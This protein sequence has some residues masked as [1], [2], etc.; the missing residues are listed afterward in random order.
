MRGATECAKRLKL[1]FSS[2]RSKLGKVGHPPLSDP[3]TQMALGILSRDTPE[4]KACEGLDRLRG[5]VVDYNELRV[6]P[7]IELAEILADF[8]DARLKCEDISR[9]L[10]AVFALEHTVSLERLAE[11]PKKETLAYL[12]ELDGLEAYTVA[13]LRLLGLRQ[14]AIPLD[15]AMWALARREQIVH[16]RCPLRE[17]QQF[18]ERQIAE[19][20]ALEFV[21]LLKRHAWNELGAAVERGE[22]ER[23]T[24]KPP[25]RTARNMLQ[26]ISMGGSLEDEAEPSREEDKPPTPE[27]KPAKQ[28]AEPKVSKEPRPA[29]RRKASQARPAKTAKSTTKPKPKVKP[30]AKAKPRATAKKEAKTTKSKSAAKK[31]ARKSSGTARRKTKTTAKTRARKS[32]AKAKS[33]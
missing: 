4:A 9:A 19:E 5:V 22:V 26:M 1:F 17:A 27:P 13:R 14:H 2:L 32:V 31:S 24:S 18:L 33:A 3:I 7:P 6:I 16:P 29:R 8:P 12:E 30:K 10:N 11:L 28:V 15:E 20:D 25:D 21:A 23:I